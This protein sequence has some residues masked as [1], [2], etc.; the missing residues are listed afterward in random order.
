MAQ[1]FRLL[2]GLRARRSGNRLGD[3]GAK[4][5]AEAKGESQAEPHSN[6][7]YE[8]AQD[9]GGRR[10]RSAQHIEQYG[11]DG[12]PDVFP[13]HEVT[14]AS[15]D[16]QDHTGK[17]QSRRKTENRKRTRRVGVSKIG[18]RENDCSNRSTP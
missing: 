5:R 11:T 3:T 18:N 4:S 13:K 9:H 7:A 1:E 8:R 17:G 2:T 12:G 16:E 14:I 15:I 10:I 6:P